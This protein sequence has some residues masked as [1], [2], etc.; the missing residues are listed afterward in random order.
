MAEKTINDSPRI[1]DTVIFDIETPGADGCFNSNPYKVDKVSIYFID[2]NFLGNN[3]GQYDKFTYQN[4]LL[5]NVLKAENFACTNPTDA[6]IAKAQQLRIELETSAQ[7]NTFYFNDA[8]AVQSVGSS[9]N[10]A[11]IS[12]DLANASITLIENDIDG[13]TQY[14]RFQYSWSPNGSVREGDY[15]ICWTWTPLSAGE[16]LSS[17]LQFTLFGDPSA[18]TTI[19]S[20]VTA[21][22]KYET[23]LERYLP[24][25]YKQ[26]ISD[27][28]LTPEVT[29]KLNQSVAKGFTVLEDFSNQII[30]LY[31]ANALHESLLVY[32]ANLFNLKLKSNDPTL[33]RRQIKEAIPLFKRKG[34]IKG[35]E[36]AFSQAGMTL[37]KLTR[38]WQVVSPYTWQESFKA[39]TTPKFRLAKI[40]LSINHLNFALWLKREGESI[41]TQIDLDNIIFEE[42]DCNLYTDL[43]W[44]GDEKSANGLNLYEGDY[45][46][47][48][49][50]YSTI[51]TGQQTIENYIRT[52]PLADLRD[53]KDQEYPLKNWN[54]RLIEEDDAFFNLIIGV[55]HPFH[56]PIV[57]GKI[58]TE[59]PYSENIFNMEEYN[60]SIRDTLDPCLIDKT[61][62]DPCGNCISSKFNIDIAVE[63][64]SDD[65]VVE[66]KDILREY[67]PFHAV[68]HQI[69]FQGD[70][71]EFVLPPVESIKFLISFIKNDIILSGDANSIF[72]RM[73]KD[74][75]SNIQVTRSDLADQ[76]E[77]VS[78][79]TGTAYNE[80][81]SLISPD[82]NLAD[83][84]IRIE[85]HV[86]EILSPS[87][88]S[89]EYS[90]LT[91]NRNTARVSTNVTEPLNQSMFT[92]RVLNNQYSTAIANIYQDN[93]FKFND[94]TL[95][96][97]ELGVKSNWDSINTT[98]YTGDAWK[99][100]IPAY[101]TT[102]YIIDKVD[103]QGNLYLLD[104]D[105]TLPDA[106]INNL[107]YSLLDDSNS[108]LGVSLAG[109]LVIENRASIHF[110]DSHFVDISEFI[111][112]GDV[113]VYS[114]IEYV[115]SGIKS[116]DTIY[117]SD[118]DLGD[119]VGVNV[120]V[121]RIILNNEVGYFGYTGLKLITTTNYETSLNILNGKNAPTSDIT[122]NSLFKENYLIKIN[123]NYYR[124]QE[125]DGNNITLSGYPQDWMTLNSGGTLVNFDIY[126][127]NKKP[128]DIKFI[129]FDE[130]DRGGKDPIIREVYSTITNDVAV[131][132][133]SI[134][135]NDIT[136][137][138]M[139]NESISF[140]VQKRDG[141]TSQGDL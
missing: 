34:T 140:V 122:D 107:H 105:R 114:D 45:V 70:I 10:P 136:N 134:P 54:V 118:Y 61:F 77:V 135:Q 58:R 84:G 63:N 46:K 17:H 73:I 139:Q 101:S 32:L 30:D 88:N 38:L 111:K 19:P 21:Q 3:F 80:Y 24:D 6:N 91:I 1:T 96:Y 39:T 108:V 72:N 11:W 53:E 117:I 131:S 55:R 31:D 9:S 119:A 26:Y 60:G 12:N 93:L 69:N 100:S 15:F 13:N 110:N 2:R 8:I 75:Y 138:V 130:L 62:S 129:V 16:S 82:I 22:D 83:C 116:N 133:L 36:D 52:L 81:I 37:N 120:E 106:N 51:S 43:V 113:L 20:H 137:N 35:L 33:W 86:L 109:K 71:N 79:S 87:P 44:V 115:V 126:H 112:Q 97:F 25:M 98:S 94:T 4:N 95:N 7:K 90:I 78:S 56:D 125:I 99:V 40:P 102:P 85:D 27:L 141:S 68:P 76:T 50:Q 14:G 5:Q 92:F 64:I 127:F 28:D 49:Y 59:F 48:I 89:G 74:G 57:F 104:P 103:S 128:V 66:I 124:M 23:L 41:Y 67:S 65:R 29:D 42:S 47:I 121:R 132:A 123:D 18:V